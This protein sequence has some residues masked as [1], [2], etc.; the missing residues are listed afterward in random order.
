MTNSNN[1]DPQIFDREKVL[2]QMMHRFIN[3]TV[4]DVSKIEYTFRK[5]IKLTEWDD[6]L[7]TIENELYGVQDGYLYPQLPKRAEKMVK[8]VEEN[9]D[10]VT[11]QQQNQM[12]VI[13]HDVFIIWNTVNT[14]INEEQKMYTIQDIKNVMIDIISDD[15][16]VNDS[17]TMSEHKG[18]VSGLN[19]LV[20]HFTETK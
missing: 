2:N 4:N 9:K 3:R 19:M 11:P 16:W 20:N 15:E 1:N 8:F 12:E 14:I 5:T 18:I 13:M 17:H 7:A 6:T 10:K